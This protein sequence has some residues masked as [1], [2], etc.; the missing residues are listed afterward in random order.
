MSTDL[1]TCQHSAIRLTWY[2]RRDTIFWEGTTYISEYQ[3][4]PG[5]LP[6]SL[7]GRDTADVHLGQQYTFFSADKFGLW[8]TDHWVNYLRR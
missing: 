7:T 8:Q 5:S 3:V 1:L 4:R 6:D 2:T